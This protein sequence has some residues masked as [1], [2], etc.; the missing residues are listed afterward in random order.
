[1]A[2]KASARISGTLLLRVPGVPADAVMV[3]S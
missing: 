3:S 2:P 1:M